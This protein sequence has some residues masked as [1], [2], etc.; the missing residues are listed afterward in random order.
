L[1]TALSHFENASRALD[2]NPVCGPSRRLL[3]LVFQSVGGFKLVPLVVVKGL[4]LV[5]VNSLKD[6]GGCLGEIRLELLPVYLAILILI[7]VWEMSVVA[8]RIG[9]ELLLG[10][11]LRGEP[12]KKSGQC[13]K[14]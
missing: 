10:L 3:I 9:N 7:H 4:A 13:K 8:F 5:Q 11:L 6:L 2:T 1:G 12:E 14:R